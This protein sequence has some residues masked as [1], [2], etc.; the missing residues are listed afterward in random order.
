MS[1]DGRLYIVLLG[2]LW[3]KHMNA[4]IEILV[5]RGTKQLTEDPQKNSSAY[6]P[7]HVPVQ[8]GGLVQKVQNKRGIRNVRYSLIHSINKELHKIFPPNRN[9]LY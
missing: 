3:I 7:G 6:V 5:Y 2:G 1:S 4:T 8:A 9:T